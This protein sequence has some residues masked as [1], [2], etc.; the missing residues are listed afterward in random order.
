MSWYMRTHSSLRVK[1]MDRV[2]SV[3][4]PPSGGFGLLGMSERAERIGAQLRIRANLAGNRNRCHCQPL[5]E[6][7]DRPIH[8]D[9]GSDR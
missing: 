8:Y 9:S 3:G 2:L 1:T 5:S 4:V 7:H 6:N